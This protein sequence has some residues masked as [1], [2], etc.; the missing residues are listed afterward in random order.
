MKNDESINLT[1]Q[2]L[3]S[4][5]DNNLSDLNNTISKI[6][7]NTNAKS[8]NFLSNQSKSDQ[9]SQGTMSK[10]VEQ[11][12]NNYDSKS[13]KKSSLKNNYNDSDNSS[14]NSPQWIQPHVKATRS[15]SKNEQKKTSQENNYSLVL[16]NSDLNDELRI[17]ISK[18]GNNTTHVIK[19]VINQTPIKKEDK[20]I[21]LIK[22]FTGKLNKVDKQKN[23][24][25]S[26]SCDNPSF[27][28]ISPKS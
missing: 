12:N 23:T 2:L 6:S 14:S 17:E 3:T 5:I 4:S 11:L 8:E 16:N 1:K 15:S 13:N 25:N 24:F 28:D 18:N 20:K 21:N 26:F 10:S 7:L 19:E 9:S 27:V 22:M